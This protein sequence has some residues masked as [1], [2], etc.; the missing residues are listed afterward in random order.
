MKPV[1]KFNKIKDD[2]IRVYK[3][4]NNEKPNVFYEQGFVHLNGNKLRVKAFVKA[5]AVLLN[6]EKNRLIEVKESQDLFTS[7]INYT[8]NEAKKLAYKAFMARTDEAE[9]RAIHRKEPGEVFE[10]W[11]NKNKKS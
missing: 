9:F 5:H 7:T 1:D 3:I 8:E 4:L 6:R 2:Y 10:I 11:W